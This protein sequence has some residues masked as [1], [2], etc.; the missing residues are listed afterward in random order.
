MVSLLDIRGVLP[1]PKSL[2]EAYENNL[3]HDAKKILKDY[4]LVIAP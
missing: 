1:A 2:S 4:R 3:D